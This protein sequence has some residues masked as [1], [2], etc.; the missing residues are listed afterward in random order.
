MT[1]MGHRLAFLIVEHEPAQGLSTRKLLIE[2]AKHNVLTAYT[3][4]EGSRM[5]RRFPAVDA[6]VVDAALNGNERL[7]RRVKEHNPKIRVICLSPREG[8][9]ASWADETVNSH[10]P[11]ALLKMLEEMGGRTDI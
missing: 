8:A 10:D 11:A 7:A 9:E 6:V 3:S 1:K 2:S 5:F 4:E